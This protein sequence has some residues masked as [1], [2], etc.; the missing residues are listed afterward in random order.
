MLIKTVVIDPRI[1]GISGDMFVASLLD[2]GGSIDKVHTLADVIEETLDYCEKFKVKVSDVK[3]RGIRA[4]DVYLIIKEHVHEISAL[5]V[6]EYALKVGDKIGLSKKGLSFIEGVFDELISAESKVHNISPNS[7]HFHEIAS[8]DTVFDVV[9]SAMLLEDLGYL[10]DNAE[11]YTTPPAL[12]SGFVEI[13]HGVVAIPAPAT[14]EILRKHSF[15]ISSSPVEAE[16][17]TPTGAALLVSLTDTVV[18]FY[19]PMKIRKIGYGSGKKDFKKIPN[20]LRVVE[21]ETFKATSDKIVVIE[22]NLDDVT[23][24]VIGYLVQKLIKSGA[25]DVSVIPALGKKNR[26]VNI[27]KV[28]ADPVNYSDLVQILI[29]ETGTLGVRVF[30]TPRIIAER[31]KK[32]VKVKVMNKEYEVRVKTSRTRNGKLINIKPEYDDL[33]EIAEHT[34]LPLRK[35]VEIVNKQIKGLTDEI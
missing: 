25:L 20:V 19:P 24:E 6:R 13:M 26:P 23:G 7:V 33:K 28:L 22:T 21:G 34:G 16:L 27:V 17:T 12:G 8:A 18:D 14:L 3:K 10:S 30:E 35:V 9:A 15:K 29:D 11:I 5:K 32:P 4:K 1:A 2:L 31:V